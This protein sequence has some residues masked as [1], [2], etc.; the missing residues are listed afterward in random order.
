MGVLL[1]RLLFGFCCV[2]A[3]GVRVFF[4]WIFPVRE[5]FKFLGWFYGC[6]RDRA[7]S[8]CNDRAFPPIKVNFL[9]A[10]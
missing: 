9:L 5:R 2:L 1:P 10:K 6:K 3:S 7:G 8:C 4:A